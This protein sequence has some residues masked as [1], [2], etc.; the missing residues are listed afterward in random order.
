MS[1]ACQTQW[2]SRNQIS[3]NLLSNFL[4]ISIFV[5][6]FACLAKPC[7]EV[8]FHY[9]RLFLQS[10]L[11]LFDC[12]ACLCMGQKLMPTYKNFETIVRQCLIIRICSFFDFLKSSVLGLF[13]F[14]FYNRS[15]LL[16][17][18]CYLIWLIRDRISLC[19]SVWPEIT[20]Y[21]RLASYLVICLPLLSSFYN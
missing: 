12:D 3:G 10:I 14:M 15:V 4:R 1:C 16:L 13:Q 11:C 18:C 6:V 8:K 7:I 17:F 19:I 5:F 21:T 20:L 2:R 9:S